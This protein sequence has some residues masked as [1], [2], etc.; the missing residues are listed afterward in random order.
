MVTKTITVL[1]P[2]SKPKKRQFE[3]VIRPSN[4]EGKVMG[5]EWNHFPNGDALLNRLRELLDDRFH[6]AKILEHTKAQAAYSIDDDALNWLSANCD[7]ILIAVGDCGSC[8]SYVI[9]DGIL[10]EKRGIPVTC[11]VTDEFIGLARGEV[12]AMGMPDLAIVSVPHPIAGVDRRE[13]AK[14]ADNIL[15]EVIQV[16]TMPQDKLSQRAKQQSP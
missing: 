14:K 4:L 5:I 6:F 7:C 9:F 16:M 3:M 2:T 11:I 13:V 12:Q 1:D 15:E 10:F 8:T